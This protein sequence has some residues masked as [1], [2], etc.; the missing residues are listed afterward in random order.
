MNTAGVKW[1]KNF[2]MSVWPME[3]A[4]RWILSEYRITVRDVTKAL[5]TYDIDVA[6]RLLYEFSGPSIATGTSNLQRYA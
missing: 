6:A 2:I 4:E 3:L 1:E 5:E